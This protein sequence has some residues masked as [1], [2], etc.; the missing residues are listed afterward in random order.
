MVRAFSRQFFL[1]LCCL[2]LLAVPLHAEAGC[3]FTDEYQECLFESA[4]TGTNF[5]DDCVTGL[6]GQYVPAAAEELDECRYGC[7]CDGEE[8]KTAD[9]L[10][11]YQCDNYNG[12]EWESAAAGTDCNE[13]CSGST[14]TGATYYTVSGTVSDDSSGTAQAL[15]GAIISFPQGSLNRQGTSRADGSFS[16]AEVPASAYPI[17]FTARKAGCDVIGETQ[18]RVV[19]SDI[20][21]LDFTLTCQIGGCTIDPVTTTLVETTPAEH[22]V[23]L[24]WEPS[25]CAVN[26]GGYEITRCVGNIGDGTCTGA[27]ER[28]GYL[29]RDGTARHR[30]YDTT[31]E[32]EKPY[33]YF[34]NALTLDGTVVADGT[35]AVAGADAHCIGGMSEYCLT[36]P[37][38]PITELHCINDPG[39]LGTLNGF[40]GIGRCDEGNGFIE[41][42]PCAVG[43]YC[44]EGATLGCVNPSICD[45]C[46]GPFGAFIPPSEIPDLDGNTFPCDEIP[47][48]VQ[49]HT[50]YAED[51]FTS[52][53]AITSCYDYTSQGACEARSGTR[54]R[55]GIIEDGCAWQA[56]SQY[57]EF[58][59]GVC[60]P[61]TTIPSSEQ[62]SACTPGACT[63]ELCE[64]ISDDCYYNDYVE[65]EVE[66]GILTVGQCVPKTEMACRYYDTRD[67]CVGTTNTE[68]GVDAHYDNPDAVNQ[69]GNPDWNRIDGSNAIQPRSDDRLDLGTCAWIAQPNHPQGGHC[70]KN[71]NGLKVPHTVFSRY[72]DDCY[73][74]IERYDFTDNLAKCFSDNEPPTTTMPLTNGAIVQAESFWQGLAGLTP[75][76][77]DNTY[78]AEEIQT[79][80]CISET[81]NNCYPQQDISQLARDTEDIGEYTLSYYSED[82]AGNL[83]PVQEVTITIIPSTVPHLVSA[84]FLDPND[85]VIIQEGDNS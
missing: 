57:G 69:Y 75:I 81:G 47:Y 60:T 46:N 50:G 22:V 20:T 74:Y 13:Q 56:V 29:P 14:G 79:H 78:A 7:C 9:L 84:T 73:E 62:C 63:R 34:I 19:Q 38:R 53:S 55:C 12:Y 11:R 85:G 30:Y 21:D 82:P 42:E 18:E 80:F 51:I 15:E 40:T 16:F 61:V 72:T 44:H 35:N 8:A 70:V 32:L 33:C 23:T 66:T 25:S 37:H 39:T 76:V 68:V 5:Q 48:C 1:A 27:V 77:H 71:A 3:I 45:Y 2:L 59:L 83:E 4:Y 64:A 49:T 6:D 28:I 24:S 17:T 41:E 67:D 54:D 36:T 26:D 10:T 52:C 58:G 65:P 43:Q 31:F